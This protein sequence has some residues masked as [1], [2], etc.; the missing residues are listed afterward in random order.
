MKN[1]GTH[2]KGHVIKNEQMK[3]QASVPFGGVTT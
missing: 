2:F 1:Y 3:K